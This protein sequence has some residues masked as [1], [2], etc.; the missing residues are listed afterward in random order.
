MAKQKNGFD[1]IFESTAGKKIKKSVPVK[2]AEKKPAPS[3][4]PKTV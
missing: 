4:A 2:K 1:T 3:P